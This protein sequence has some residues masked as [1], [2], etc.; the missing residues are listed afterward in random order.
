M[1]FIRI[2]SGTS[3][4]G[5][6]RMMSYIL[7]DEEQGYTDSPLVDVPTALFIIEVAKLVNDREDWFPHGKWAT[8]QAIQER[9]ETELKALTEGRDEKRT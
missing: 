5:L 8:I 1:E 3:L 2:G 9:I 6:K 7:N 4:E